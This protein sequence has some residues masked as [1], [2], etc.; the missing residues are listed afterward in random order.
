MRVVVLVAD[1]DKVHVHF[2]LHQCFPIC[3]WVIT[4]ADP[5]KTGEVA[6][7]QLLDAPD[8]IEALISR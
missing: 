5:P 4:D 1:G 2:Q 3:E 8:L 6:L 7:P